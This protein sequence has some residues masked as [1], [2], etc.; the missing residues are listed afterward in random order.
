M[1]EIER[2]FIVSI[3]KPYL[4]AKKGGNIQ[5]RKTC[6]QTIYNSNRQQTLADFAVGQKWLTIK[7]SQGQIGQAHGC[8]KGEWHRKPDQTT[9]EKAV[10][11]LSG[12]GGYRTVVV[13]LVDKDSSEIA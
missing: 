6:T 10:H 4:I 13:G 2:K 1:E 12:F 7:L 9:R 5:I 3:Q 11:P 8:G